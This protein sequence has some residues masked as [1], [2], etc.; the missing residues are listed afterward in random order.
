MERLVVLVVLSALAVAVALLLQRR[1][2]DPP[3]APSYRAPRQLD[4]ADFES[5]DITVLIVVWASET[6]ATCPLVWDLVAG[7]TTDRVATQ[8]VTVQDGADLHQRY[9]IDAV[10]TTVVVD[11]Q[12]VVAK[13]YFGPVDGE[14]LDETVAQL[15]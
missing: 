14:D 8:L 9:R 5:R 1:R 7:R 11:A 15:V 2:P 6:C 12:G 10:P 3:T 13:A 4:R